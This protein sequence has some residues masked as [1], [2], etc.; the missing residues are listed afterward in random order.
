MQEFYEAPFRERFRRENE[1]SIEGLPWR[2]QEREK[3][4]LDLQNLCSPGYAEMS[5]QDW[6]HERCVG[7]DFPAKFIK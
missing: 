5:S 1:S 6:V 3:R 7:F 2:Y 4:N